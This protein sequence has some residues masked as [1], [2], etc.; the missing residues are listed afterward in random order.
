MICLAPLLRILV[1]GTCMMLASPGFSQEN[2]RQYFHLRQYTITNPEATELLDYY[3]EEALLPAL[4]RQGI[5]PIGVFRSHPSERD[6]LGYFFVLYPLA[7]LDQLA[8]LD[9]ALEK[10]ELYKEVGAPFLD[11]PYSEPPYQRQASVL[12]RAFREMPVLTPTNLDTD[13]SARVYELR[14]YESPTEAKYRNKVEMFNEGGEVTLFEELGFRAIFYGEVLSGSRMPNLMYMT[15]FQN[16]AARD[17]LWNTFFE[18]DTWKSLEKDPY[19]QHNVSQAD[20]FLLYP[21]SYSDY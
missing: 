6:S 2:Q 21:T 13:R 16:M 20:I 11:A 1:L 14:S 15:S 4:K 3:M 8:T 7:S 5:G 19:Y 10:D 17:S 18:S 9:R 12:L